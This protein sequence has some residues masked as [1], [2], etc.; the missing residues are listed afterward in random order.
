MENMATMGSIFAAYHDNGAPD[1][2]VNA[3]RPANGL[4]DH[5]KRSKLSRNHRFSFGNSQF[6]APEAFRSQHTVLAQLVRSV[7]PESA[8]AIA[9]KLLLHFGSLSQVFAA[10]KSQ[11]SLLLDEP[12]AAILTSAHSAVIESLREEVVRSV[13]DL[14]DNR[15]HRY[16]IAKFRGFADERFHAIFLDTHRRFLSEEEIAKGSWTNVDVRLR[17]LVSRAFELNAAKLVLVHNHPSGFPSPSQDDIDFTKR[18]IGVA[19]PLDVEIDDHLIVAGPH[20]YSI[21][22]ASLLS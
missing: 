1:P 3:P 4:C 6:P 21:R 18:V 12:L 10:S 9:R 19:E 20:I 17:S 16:L 22:Q 8:E 11:I 15:F 13:L 7:A 14:K 5:E 2:R